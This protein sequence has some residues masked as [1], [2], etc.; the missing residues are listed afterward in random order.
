MSL[1]AY[2]APLRLRPAIGWQPP[3]L[4]EQAVDLLYDEA[5]AVSRDQRRGYSQP[6]LRVHLRAADLDPMFGPQATQRAALPDPEPWLRQLAAAMLECMTGVRAPSQIARWVSPLVLERV[7][8]RNV[9]ARRR[10]AHPIAPPRVRKV[11]VCEPDDGV[12]EA[13]IVVHH[14]GRVRALA[15]R[16]VGVDGRWMVT[17]MELG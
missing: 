5:V 10:G 9:I 14:Q 12:A 2:T 17:A 1:P 3:A 11:H 8:R 7:N 16:L 13:S 6:T 4:D 15:L